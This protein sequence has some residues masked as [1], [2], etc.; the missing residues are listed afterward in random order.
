MPRQEDSSDGEPS[1]ASR[2]GRPLVLWLAVLAL[3]IGFVGLAL[4]GIVESRP[5][6][7]AYEGS[8]Q[9]KLPAS[10]AHA[11]GRS[12]PATRAGQPV[13]S[14]ASSPSEPGRPHPAKGVRFGTLTIPVLKQTLPIIEGTDDAQLDRGVGHFSHSALPGED[15]NCV[16]SGHRDTVFTGLGKV[17]VGARL[18]VRTSAG[19]YTYKVRRVRIV[20]KD[21]KTV[22]VPTDHAVLTVTTCY[23]FRY[24]GAAPDRYVLDA[25]LISSK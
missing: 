13:G 22:I 6:A 17:G 9:P 12:R 11:V 24:V 18:I 1:P 25:D 2:G 23:P 20:H 14:A 4:A 21:D 19:E 5:A 15:N 10:D 3:G 7:L 8:S 16:L